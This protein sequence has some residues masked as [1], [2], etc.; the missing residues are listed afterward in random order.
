[1][2][3]ILA[4]ALSTLLTLT[5]SAPAFPSEL[6]SSVA[7]L[8]ARLPDLPNEASETTKWID[9]N[10][11]LIH[12]GLL[13]LQ[14]DIKAHQEA[15][16]RITK[17]SAIRGKDQGAIAAQDIS[18]G[19]ADAGIDVDRMQ[20]DPNY[21]K[22]VQARISQMSPQQVV[23]LSQQMTR[24]LNNDKRYKNQAKAIVE[25]APAVREAAEAGASRV[26][27][28]E[29]IR[30]I[31]QDSEKQVLRILNKP[32][33][34]AT[35]KPAIE[36]ESIGCNASCE[37]QWDAYAAKVLPLM[38]ARDTEILRVHRTA[39]QRSRLAIA[40]GIRIADRHLRAAQYGAN[41]QSDSN[42]MQIIGYDGA[43]IGEILALI[44]NT[45]NSARTAAIVS[46]CGKQIVLAPHAIC[47]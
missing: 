10:G 31:W 23:A 26:S 37:A 45:I 7:G 20:R 28:L 40:D 25:D 24:P 39:L 4:C 11:T 17:V 13:A 19:I 1:V 2:K 12:P 21:A 8:F 5:F 35:P 30:A 34:I 44:D 6:P 33:P 29:E 36:W 42:Q 27:R 16:G 9:K 41:S 15:I 14:A 47:R 43:A 32:L 22:E 3:T 46:H 38:I 18:Q